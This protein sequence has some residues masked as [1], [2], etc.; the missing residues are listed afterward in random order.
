MPAA[1][2]LSAFHSVPQFAQDPRKQQASN[3]FVEV[4]VVQAIRGVLLVRH[5]A[6]MPDT[7]KLER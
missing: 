7:V 5:L 3:Q 1:S 2:L 6:R 4:V